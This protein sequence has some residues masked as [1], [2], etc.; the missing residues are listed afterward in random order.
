MIIF[1]KLKKQNINH[2]RVFLTMQRKK[3]YFKHTNIENLEVLKNYYLY[4]IMM[5]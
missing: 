5:K 1:L 2:E 4:H 3:K